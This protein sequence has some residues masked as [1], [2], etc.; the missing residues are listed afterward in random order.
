MTP[1]GMVGYLFTNQR[2][3][4]SNGVFHAADIVLQDFAFVTT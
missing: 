1:D 2:M 3:L 4:L